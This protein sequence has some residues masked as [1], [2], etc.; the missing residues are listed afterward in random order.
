LNELRQLLGRK[1]F[2]EMM[3]SFGREHAGK[4]VTS[5]EFQAYAERASGKD[6][7]EFF[8]A[9]LRLAGL[10]QLQL[11]GVSVVRKGPGDY[12]VR[13]EITCAEEKGQLASLGVKPWSIRTPAT[14]V[15]VA[16]TTSDGDEII[17]VRLESGT[18]S[19][20]TRTK[21]E[22]RRVSV[23]G[24]GGAGIANGGIFSVMSFYGEL[25]RTLIAYGTADE[26]PTNREA[27]ESLQ[28][29]IRAHYANFTVP[30][31][32]AKDVTPDE[33]KSNHL[34]LIGRPDSNTLIPGCQAALPITL[35]WRSFTVGQ[36][37]FAHP[38]SAVVVAADN[39]HNRRY[40]VV[41]LAGLSAEATL[42]IPS[43]LMNQG[44]LA[45][46]VLILPNRGKP[47][48]LVIPAKELVKDLETPNGDNGKKVA[49]PAGTP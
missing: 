12:E 13:G 43:G 14:T 33:L 3:D 36:E 7:K 41:V 20:A 19:F 21:A 30:I 11:E 23:N 17:P 44:R 40:S 22:P 39:P 1:T 34:L 48:A 25:E 10:P 45:P 2:E 35:G 47:R 42:N 5:A 16:V 46:E 27:A 18:V 9:W 24:Y 4:E 31:K 8:D 37:T 6:L 29:A 15:Q 38:G 32:A 26:T 49:R 28:Q